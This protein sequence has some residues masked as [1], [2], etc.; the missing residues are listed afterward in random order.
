MTPDSTRTAPPPFRPDRALL[1][2]AL[3]VLAAKL[4]LIAGYGNATP[5][6]DEW[7]EEGYYF[8]APLVKGELPLGELFASHYEHRVVL[9][10]LLNIALLTANGNVW[11][12]LLQMIVNAGLHVIG[13]LILLVPLRRYCPPACRTQLLVAATLLF[14]LPFN[15]DNT[16]CGF[17]SQVY[18][19]L[20]FSFLFLWSM[21]VN[22]VFSRRWWVGLACG[23]LACISFGSG[24]AT[25]ACGAALLLVRALCRPARDRHELFAAVLL[26][27]LAL[28]SIALTPATPAI[29]LSPKAG[30]VGEFLLALLRI[31]GWPAMPLLAPLVYLPLLHFMWRQLRQPPPAGHLSWFVFAMGLWTL[32]QMVLLAYGRGKF[33][34]ASRYLDYYAIGLLLNLLCLFRSWQASNADD[35]TSSANSPAAR[36]FARGWM[37]AIPLLLLVQSQAQFGLLVTVK[38]PQLLASERHI[39]A[40]LRTGNDAELTAGDFPPPPANLGPQDMK[41][42]LDDPGM[43]Q[44]LPP[45]LRPENGLRQAHWISGLIAHLHTLG[46]LLLTLGLGLTLHSWLTTTPARPPAAG[47]DTPPPD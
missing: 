35:A 6:R 7:A 36:W 8:F 23:G 11:N 40:Y 47:A 16:L 21:S 22:T 4:L 43:V 38:L 15:Y 14:S 41:Q 3:L 34:L 20:I 46:L 44:V 2:F 29:A 37:I 25:L 19:V 45:N 1:A 12:P 39:H 26:T 18:F 32:A 28:A 27:G 31:G 24:A 33:P 17:Q 30:S 9:T 10:R 42:V 13:L 5:S